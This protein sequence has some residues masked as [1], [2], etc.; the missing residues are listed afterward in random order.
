MLATRGGSTV[1]VDGV[2]DELTSA[3]YDVSSTGTLAYVSGSTLVQV[4]WK[5]RQGRTLPLTTEGRHY[6]FPVLSPDGKRFAVTITEGFVRNLW[7]GSVGREPLT[8]LTFGNDDVFGVW[9]PDGEQIVFTSGQGGRYNLFLT[10]ADASGRLERLTDDSHS[11]KPTSV[12]PSGDLVLFNDDTPSTG[13]DIW[14]ASLDR[15]DS[16]RPYIQTR[17][18][19]SEGMFSPDGRWVAYRSDETGR[20]E[21]YVQ[22]YPIPAG[23]KRVSVNGGTAPAWNPNGRELIYHTGDALMTVSVSRDGQGLRIDAPELLFLHQRDRR[24]PGLGTDFSV[25]PDGQRFLMPAK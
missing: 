21:V 1:A 14:Q 6:G 17:F 3:M 24:V 9:T 13:L 7:V 16:P 12:S 8:Q 15:R 10:P 23:K 25:A 22:A 20:Y 2:S 11:Q 4:V 19:E 18:N 5:D